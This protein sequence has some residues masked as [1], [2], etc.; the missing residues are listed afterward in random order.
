MEAKRTNRDVVL[1]ILNDIKFLSSSYMSQH[2][3]KH[4][5]SVIPIPSSIL[6]VIGTLGD[7]GS[8]SHSQSGTLPCSN[9]SS[10][11][12]T[13][14]VGL[15]SGVPGYKAY[16]PFWSKAIDVDKLSNMS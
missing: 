10:H 6:I 5:K 16:S 11:T 3:A 2:Y 12:S 7:L 15:I 4:F 9:K 14:V 8:P 13:E 1:I